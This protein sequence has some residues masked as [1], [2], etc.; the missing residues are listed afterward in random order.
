MLKDVRAHYRQTGEV[1]EGQVCRNLM[2]TRVNDF[3][4]RIDRCHVQPSAIHGDGLFASRSMVAGELIT[5]FP[6]DALLVWEDG[7]RKSDMMIF[8]GAHVPQS[9]RDANDIA[10]ERVQQYE[11]YSSAWI[12]AVGDPSRR[13]DSSYLGHFAN[14]GCMCISPDLVEAYR[15]ESPGAANCE[16]VLLEGCHFALQALKPIEEG[17]ELLFSYGEGYWLARNGHDGVG[18][19]L[20]CIGTAPPTRLQMKEGALLKQALQRARKGATKKAGAGAK[21]AKKA[22]KA[23]Q[24]TASRGFGVTSP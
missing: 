22:K 18:V 6:G 1:E 20:R 24:Q 17:D 7:D 21:R 2:V 10:N 5:F 19:D 9:E 11:L 3:A 16:A 13:D 12:S 23:T 8:F 4:N 14:D 15:Q